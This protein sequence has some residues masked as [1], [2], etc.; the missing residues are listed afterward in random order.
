MRN[1]LALVLGLSL[2]FAVAGCQNNKT[3]PT[4]NTSTAADACTHCAGQQV[5]TA[6]GKCPKCG[7]KVANK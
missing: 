3:E 1:A 2:A 6:D 5:A 7:M 4:S